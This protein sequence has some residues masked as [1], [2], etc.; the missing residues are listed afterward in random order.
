MNLVLPARNQTIR[1]MASARNPYYV[2]FDEQLPRDVEYALER[3][4][5][6]ELELIESMDRI[7]AEIHQ[8]MGS[9]RVLQLFSMVDV[10]SRH[11]ISRRSLS[12]FF[13]NMG[14]HILEEDLESVMRRLDKDRDGLIS[15]LEFLDAFLPFQRA[16]IPR[17]DYA[18]RGREERE[19]EKRRLDRSLEMRVR[20][21][22]FTIYNLENN[23]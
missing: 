9:N 5:M 7:K 20:M 12:E 1:R 10:L 11:N 19:R 23:K 3:L 13:E 14:K 21:L 16:K 17:S 2:G 6:K 18:W 8:S 4:I 15:Y 22:R